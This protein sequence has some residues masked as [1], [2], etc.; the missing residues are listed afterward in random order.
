[1]ASG[2][3]AINIGELAIAIAL[4]TGAL[5]AGLKDVQNKL[6]DHGKKV[7]Q[8]GADYDKLAIVAGVAFYKIASAIGSGVKAFNDFN[9]SMIG[10]KSV[11]QGTGN[12]FSQAQG[13]IDDFTKDGLIVAADAATAL[14]N[15]L[16]RG[17]GLGEASTILN[18][19]KDS[20]AFGRQASLSLGEAVKGATEGLKNEN[21]VL[22]DN[23][24]VTKNVS[25][26][27]KEYATSIG[28]GVDSLTIAEK[29]QAELTGI[30]NET[31]FQIGDAAK[32]SEQFAGAQA[33]AAA[34]SVKLNQALGGAVVPT[35]NVL[36]NIVTPVI[37]ALTSFV[38]GNPELVAALVLTATAFLGII[39][40]VTSVRAAIVL[41]G[42]ALA[43]L[44]ISLAGLL[45]NPVVLGL[46]ALAVVGG[47]VAAQVTK[48]KKAQNEYNKALSDYN[49][50]KQN[51][52]AK[53][54]VPQVQEEITNIQKLIKQYDMLNDRYKELS[55]ENNMA[56]ALT[57][58]D[59]AEKE[60]G[61]NAQ[62]L[63]EEFKKLGLNID[64]FSGST[65]DA[66]DKL[67]T[68]KSAVLEASRVTALE[69]NAQ[70][71]DIA[72]KRAILV[73]TQNLI[74]AYNS[75][76]T[77]TK[78][79]QTA[80]QALADQ[81]PQ[82]STASGIE[83][84]AIQA[85][86][87]AQDAAVK[88]EWAMLKAK[89]A[90]SKQELEVII[91][92]KLESIKALAVQQQLNDT[93]T[94][95]ITGKKVERPIMALTPITKALN[96]LAALKEEMK[97]M[98]AFNNL[99]IDK[100]LG[101]KPT[102]TP[103]YSSYENAALDSA[104]K[105]HDHRVR[106]EELTKEEELADLQTILDAYAQT[107]DERMS[108]EEQIYLARQ[109]LRDRDLIAAQKAIDDEA[110]KLADRTANSERW[111][112]R[113]KTTGS[114]TGQEEIDSYNRIIKYH[115]EYL[116]KI[117]ADTQIAQDDKDKIIA[118]ET[119]TIQDQQD[120]IY[121]IQKATV[122]K[123]VNAYI[124]AKKKQYD[125]EESLENDRLNN[126]LKAL[127]KEY[128][129]KENALNV[130]DRNNELDSLYAEERKYQNAAT[131]EGQDKLKDIRTNIAS[132]NKEAAQDSLTAEKETRKA[133]IEQEVADNQNKYKR[134]NADLETEK[135][136]MLNAA[137]NYAQKANEALVSGQAA[138][139]S[140]LA[141][142]MKNFDIQTTDMI[143]QGMEKLR[144]LIEGYKTIMDSISLSP[145]FQ[146]AGTNGLNVNSV[147]G[148]QGSTVTI[149]DYGAKYLAGIDD[150][151]DY[152]GELVNG[153]ENALKG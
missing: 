133:A 38:K 12:D 27:W 147:N 129:D 52:I 140:S 144:Q 107:A 123:A 49:K 18:R 145:N 60:T 119:R 40:V 90:I 3:R 17:F 48:A 7:Q 32:Y 108:L 128:S 75:A 102:T 118:D 87:D 78:E 46:T 76:Q 101:I 20:A 103:D 67:N 53:T 66:T 9:N 105:I 135:N 146:L 152:G 100:V 79:W 51:G 138:V 10:L 4:K 80:Q 29:R 42:P 5:E 130:A 68:L 116:D 19:F 43:A 109:E 153:A 91:T 86:T 65:K 104:M 137:V 106:M 121:E 62:K 41:L 99:D 132:L 81:F 139:A 141:G 124:D 11:V 44:K 85:V 6:K 126:K 125:T 23:A 14:K 24:G 70:A 13:F 15:L 30:M 39:T 96:D 21:S 34:E 142:I 92:T 143:T 82:F 120:K 71:K 74:K 72:Q 151:Q 127:D 57:V 134:L 35:L 45:L 33:K 56:T 77:G 2:G 64:T 84:K 150:I 93:I 88:A 73:E 1:M 148:K 131:K 112:S 136:N 94:A 55:K 114:L 69:Y 26:M 50:I 28:K 61:I 117:I 36:L 113:E 115:Q 111:I 122:D 22:V 37:S 110:K 16:A 89:I 98:D 59:Q 83:I 25:V 8:T 58:F 47:V 149:N 97:T 54:E 63:S 95:A 31:R